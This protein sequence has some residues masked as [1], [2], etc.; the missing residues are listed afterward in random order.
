MNVDDPDFQFFDP[1]TTTRPL[2]DPK[3]FGNP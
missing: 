1:V 3:S 2:A